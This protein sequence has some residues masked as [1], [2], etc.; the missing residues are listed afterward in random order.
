MSQHDNK[1]RDYENRVP[2]TEAERIAIT[3]AKLA[4]NDAMNE[5][6]AQLGVARGS[7][8]SMEE[9]KADIRFA[10]ALR[11]RPEIWLDIEFIHALRCGS[12]KAGSRV[13]FTLLTI[14]TVGI[15][16]WIWQGFIT[17]I[18]HHAT[19]VAPTVIQH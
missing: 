9:F 17:S 8:E 15:A 14:I 19:E 12:A 6:F 18:W 10:R 2:T 16:A 5:L 3:A 11:K 1:H 7:V 13:F 4:V